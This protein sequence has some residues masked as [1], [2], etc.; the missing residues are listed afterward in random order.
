MASLLKGNTGREREGGREKGREIERERRRE[1][2]EGRVGR[3]GRG[4]GRE[5]GREIGIGQTLQHTHTY[6]QKTE[7]HF[8]E[9]PP[10][11]KGA[12]RSK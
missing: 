9:N 8:R 5:G 3:G 7:L 11:L 6:T 2:G 12:P 1:G 10:S 4:G